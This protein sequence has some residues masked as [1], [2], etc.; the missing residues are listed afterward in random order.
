MRIIIR[1]TGFAVACFALVAG[2]SLAWET[3][4]A[5]MTSHYSVHGT[6]DMTGSALALNTLDV[7]VPVEYDTDFSSPA[8]THVTAAVPTDIDPFGMEAAPRTLAD[9]VAAHMATDVPDA[10]YECLAG[11]VYFESKGEPLKGQLSV[12]EVI[13]NR[14]QSGR[15]PKSLCGV[16]KQRHQFSFIRAGRFPPIP[17]ASLAWKKAVA[18]IA[19]NDLAEGGAPD[20]LF[21]H[22]KYV[23]PRWKR[24]K[25]VAT[26]GNHIFYR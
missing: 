7:P 25:R 24:L 6:A 2:P 20:A 22:A 3:S 18:V 16:V 14:S 21:F 11:A 5:P 15:F 12:A 10:E 9:L 19:M 23:S 26:V 4:E 8:D 1:A 13:I 17:K